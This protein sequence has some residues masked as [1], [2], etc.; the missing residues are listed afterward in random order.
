MRQKLGEMLS[1]ITWRHVLSASVALVSLGLIVW[2][3]VVAWQRPCREGA[4]I[5]LISSPTCPS[6]LLDLEPLLVALGFWAVGLAVWCAGQRGPMVGFFLLGAGALATG[7]LSAMGSD[8][9]GRL[10]YLL[11]A[12]LAPLTFH[13]HLTLLGRPLGRAGRIISRGLY[14]LAAVLSLPVL[15][16]TIATL[17][18]QDWFATWRVGVRLGVALALALVTLLLFRDYRRRASPAARRRI[19]LITFGTIFAFTPLL[20]L[21]LLPDTLGA[22]AYVPYEFTFPWLLL[23]PLAYGYSLFRHRLVRTEV[24]LNRA[25]VYYLLVTLLLG[26]YLAA[27]AALNLLIK[28]RASHW[29]LASGLLSV[30]LLLLFAPLKRGLQ[31][32]TNWI[33]YGGEIS[34]VSVVGRLAESLSL[35]LDRKTLRHLLLDEL[36]SAMRLSSSALFLRDQDNTLAL[37]DVTGFEAGGIPAW[38]LP[39]GGRLAAYLEAMAEPVADV[40]VRRALAGV[41]LCAEEQ[42]LLS[43]TGVAFWL[44]L[45]SGDTLQGL[46]LIGPRPGGDFFTAE[47]ERILATVARQ[48]GIAAHNVR[49]AEQVRA[50]RQE[51]ARAHQQLLVGREREQRRLAQEL[52]DGAVQQLMGISYQIAEEGRD[53]REERR[54][55][56]EGSLEIIRREVLGVATQLRRL[57]GELRP[58][59]LEELGLTAALEGYVARLEREGGP[60]MPEIQLDLDKS[61]TALPEAVALCLFRAAQEAL[62]NG[63]KHAQA[64]HI[65]VSLRLTPSFPPDACPEPSRRVGGEQRGGA[66]LNVRDDGCGFRVPARLSE[67]T[68]ADHFGLV[69]I[70]ERVAWAGGQFTIHS[71]PGAGTEVTVRIPYGVIRET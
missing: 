60:E 40:Q 30:G 43:L 12:W 66:V 69:G 33:W 38:R 51:L 9:G 62:R 19:R 32:L 6:L 34:Y 42:A 55:R 13:F 17:E 5:S 27:A 45:V 31:Q 10:F 23:S 44:P 56:R 20:L 18:Q 70:A 21:S 39:G 8:A 61:G 48:S 28:S 37:A 14:G 16:W 53:R 24:A 59:G 7:K 71:Q 3:G 25:A 2:A 52:H 58:A 57:I 36:A 63:L 46:L 64:E 29:P 11:L 22:P 47:D 15:C 50:G 35:T 4:A 65:K 26:V 41:T 68:Q 49:L 67:L 1:S 54:E